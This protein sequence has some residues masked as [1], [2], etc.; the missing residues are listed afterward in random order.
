MPLPSTLRTLAERQYGLF[1]RRQAAEHGGD[2]RQLRRSA[3]AGDCALVSSRVLRLVGAPRTFRQRCV[4]AVLD[5]GP[6]GAV[7][8][9]AAAKLW[10]LPGFVQ[11]EIDLS[12]R[13]G[14]TSRASEL[15]VLHEPRLLPARHITE[16]HGIP[17]TTMARTVFDLAASLHPLRT[18]RALDNALAR[19]LTT[20]P[21][22]RSVTHDLADHGRRGSAVMRGLLAARPGAYIAPESGLE[23]RFLA[24]LTAAGL[25]LPERQ[26]D[27]GGEQWIGR[28]DFLD[29]A[30][31]LV[32]EIDSDIHHTTRAD[33]RA[34][35]GRSRALVE[36]GYGLVRVREE[37]VWHRPHEVIEALK[38]S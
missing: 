6:G 7:S 23:A 21:A 9:S 16:V 12:R 13:R 37:Q 28:V 4:A 36:A 17:V 5:G 15:A 22:L 32:I 29:R 20:L 2:A 26:R 3:A 19:R 14:R 34:D 10:D 33:R 24:I 35:D 1:S 38:A 25:P 31:R 8:H 30:R 18:E 27:V 11:G